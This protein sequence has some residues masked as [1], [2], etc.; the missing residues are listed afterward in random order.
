MMF[1][2][3][4]VMKSLYEIRASESKH[5][6]RYAWMTRARVERRSLSDRLILSLGEMLI[7]YGR[8]LKYHVNSQTCSQRSLKNMGAN[9]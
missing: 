4:R 5:R 3:P 9:I 7:A 8:K 2:D 6:N 1:N